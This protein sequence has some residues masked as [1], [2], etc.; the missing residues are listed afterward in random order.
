MEGRSL[1]STLQSSIIHVLAA[2]R[3]L[4]ETT[5]NNV[6]LLK[7]VPPIFGVIKEPL[8]Q[9]QSAVRIEFQIIRSVDCRRC[10]DGVWTTLL[11]G[12]L[13]SERDVVE[14]LSIRGALATRQEGD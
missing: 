13:I 8:G 11:V 6:D 12:I 10:V 3:N 4:K 2:V 1:H 14:I 7:S 9:P 5:P